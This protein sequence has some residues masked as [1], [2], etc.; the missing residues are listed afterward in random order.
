[1]SKHVSD[2]LDFFKKLSL[3]RPLLTNGPLQLSVTGIEYMNDDPA[4][5]DVLYGKV[6]DTSGSLVLQELANGI[7]KYFAKTGGFLFQFIHLLNFFVYLNFP[8]LQGS[9]QSS[10]TQL[11]FMLPS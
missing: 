6:K 8:S 11:N 9:C 10:L 4:E 5:V 7:I 1:M 2:I 3:C